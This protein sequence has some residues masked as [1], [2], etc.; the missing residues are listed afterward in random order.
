MPDLLQATP[1]MVFE[2]ARRFVNRR[3]YTLQSDTP[4][5][6]SGRHYYYRPHRRG[7]PLE[8]TPWDIQ[9]HLAGEITLG[10]YAIN[11]RTQRVKWMAI[12]ADYRKALE[13]LLKLR[14]WT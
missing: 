1:E 10:I 2:Y 12:D 9:R 8:L 14:A 6:A 13:N 3:A 7:N 5:P 4:H 11:P